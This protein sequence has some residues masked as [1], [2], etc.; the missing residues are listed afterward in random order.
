MTGD[1]VYDNN[2]LPGNYMA[3]ILKEMSAI[4]PE[5]FLTHCMF[6]WSGGRQ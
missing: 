5:E 6:M 3:G 4:S 2:S 1:K